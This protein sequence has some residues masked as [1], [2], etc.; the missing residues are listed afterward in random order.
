MANLISKNS[1]SY[2][3][4]SKMVESALAKAAQLGCDQNVAVVD[5]GGNLLAF[6][7][8]DNAPILGI[9]GAQRKAHTSLLGV[10]TEAFYEAIKNH[11]GTVHGLSHLPGSIMVPGG[12]PIIIDGEVVG[13]IGSSGGMPE[14][15]IA[16]SQAG[17]DAI[18]TS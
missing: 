16:C 12:L 10:G 15:D 1:V 6:G 4:A 9:E 2:V 18:A 5:C 13:G 7:R 17:I 14:E 3:D 8:M 11:D